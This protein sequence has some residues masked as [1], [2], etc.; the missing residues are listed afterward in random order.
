MLLLICKYTLKIVPTPV[1]VL[2][3]PAL[4]TEKYVLPSILTPHSFIQHSHT[5]V[6]DPHNTGDNKYHVVTVR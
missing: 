1:F 4:Q 2:L 6:L 5:H 3:L